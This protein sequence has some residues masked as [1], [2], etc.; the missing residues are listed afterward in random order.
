[1]PVMDVGKVRVRMSD[2][3]VLMRMR[4]WLVTVPLKVV[5]MLVMLVVPVSMVVVQGLV[6]VRV[7]MSLTYMQPDPERH[8]RGR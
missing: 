6:S 5:S 2:G 3:Q 7:F 8:E 4:M 1:M